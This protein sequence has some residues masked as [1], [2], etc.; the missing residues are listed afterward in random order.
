MKAEA[1]GVM[2]AFEAAQPTPATTLAK[3]PG[4]AIE[5]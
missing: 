3:H 2:L 5:S 1:M 4:F